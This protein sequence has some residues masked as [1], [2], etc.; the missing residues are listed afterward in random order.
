MEPWFYERRFLRPRF[1]R[2]PFL[3]VLRRLSAAPR[4]GEA[5]TWASTVARG[6]ETDLLVVGGGPAGVS[7]AATAGRAG[8]PVT[9]VTAG[10]AGGRQPLGREAIERVSADL[11]AARDRNVEMLEDTLCV[12]Y[13]ADERVFAAVDPLGPLTI[14][15]DRVIVATG[16]YDRAVV[17]PGIDLP[18]VMGARAFERL[19]AQ[20]AFTGDHRIGVVSTAIEAA[21][22]AR[23]A[24]AAGLAVSWAVGPDDRAGA[25][26]YHPDRRLGRIRGRRAARGVTL[27]D[28]ARLPADVVVI[29]LTQP[30]YELQLHLGQRATIEGEPPTVRTSGPTLVP[31]L[32]VGEAVDDIEPEGA[33]DRASERTSA[34]LAGDPVNDRPAPPAVAIAAGLDAR[35]TVCICEDVT[36]AAIDLA[37][38][39]GFGDIELLKRRSGACTGA[40]QGKLCLGQVGEVLRSRGLDAGLPTMRPPV[41]PVPIAQLSAGHR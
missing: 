7:A 13:Y 26:D 1:A 2:Q 27:D 10:P 4:L 3:A 25:A 24:D 20:G 17:V 22:V 28:G 14:R 30:T 31:M 41:R 32:E 34:W 39:D 18:G 33:S 29:G 40:C 37:I 9:L 11:A 36:V 12:G 16:A 35:A 38:A 19:S 23:A 21:R 15:A 8:M 5:T 6:I